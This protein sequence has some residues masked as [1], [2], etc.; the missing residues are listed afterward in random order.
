MGPLTDVNDKDLPWTEMKN[1][2]SLRLSSF[3]TVP[4]GKD[5]N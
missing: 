5:L 1:I 3:D 2:F 4:K